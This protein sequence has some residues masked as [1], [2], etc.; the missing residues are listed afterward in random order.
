MAGPGNSST[1][2]ITEQTVWSAR[3]LAYL[4]KTY[5]YV[6][7]LTNRDYEGE[8]RKG[9]TV[10]ILQI[11][12]VAVSDF[13][14]PWADADWQA[15]NASSLDFQIDQEKKFLFKVPRVRQQ[16]NEINLIDQG[17]Q[18]A[19]VAV[20]DVVDQYIASKQSQVDT[21]NQY[22]TDAAPVTVGFGAGQ[23]KPTIAL[24]M[25]QKKLTDSRAPVTDPRVVVP[26]WFATMLTI[27]LSGRFT[28]LGDSVIGG[29]LAAKPGYV[30]K[31]G[32]WSVYQS[33]NVPNVAG[34]KYKILGGNPQITYAS[35]IEE[36]QTA[37]LQNDF[38]TGVKGLYVYGARLPL[39]RAMTVGTFNEGAY[40]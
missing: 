18:R 13:T 16:F 6:S 24:A 15:L 2:L 28:A 19:A 35:A 26:G 32:L 3:L 33:G 14:G 23:T 4:D 22:G 8:A 17:S 5:V 37:A 29:Q 10:K 36:V 34:T 39:P 27:E 12:D 21:A 31:V 38:G 20:G 11:G 40:Q 25:L 1:P 9:G 30:G 7:A